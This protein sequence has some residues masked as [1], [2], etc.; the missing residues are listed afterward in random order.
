M[1]LPRSYAR[2]L[3]ASTAELD[4]SQNIAPAQGLSPAHISEYLSLSKLAFP[5]H[6]NTPLSPYGRASHHKHSTISSSVA[7]HTFRNTSPYAK[8][9]SKDWQS[10][11]P[12]YLKH[13]HHGVPGLPIPTPAHQILPHN[14]P[15][16]QAVLP[17]IHFGIPLH[18][19][20]GSQR[21]G[22]AVV[23]QWHFNMMFILRDAMVP[24]K[25]CQM[26]ISEYLSSC[27]G[28]SP[29]IMAPC[30]FI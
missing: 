23:Q 1:A 20:S 27:K 19:Q 30:L 13:L 5:I 22:R 10:S 15:Q 16:S 28:V 6:S 29:S 26:Y 8:R 11:G 14:M 17:N 12:A 9:I 24:S 3:K 2:R 21:T 18:M 7:K 4:H 25:C